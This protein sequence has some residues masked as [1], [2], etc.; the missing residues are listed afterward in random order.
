MTTRQL[1]LPEF[2]KS[3]EQDDIEDNDC[4]AD[5]YDSNTLTENRNLD[6]TEHG[7][8]SLSYTSITQ[9]VE[10]AERD[11]HETTMDTW[12]QEFE[13]KIQNQVK[14]SITTAKEEI[15]QTISTTKG[16]L[17]THLDTL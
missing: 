2:I 17:L 9:E 6:T 14:T 1:D 10:Q 3:N 11:L 12:K 4:I 8:T 7:D 13:Y 15:L 5:S 16:E